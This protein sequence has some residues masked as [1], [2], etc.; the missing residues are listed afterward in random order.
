MK[1]NICNKYIQVIKLNYH[2]V[3]FYI[4]FNWNLMFCLKAVEKRYTGS[5]RFLPINAVMKG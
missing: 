2:K 1:N 4:F 3:V 5:D